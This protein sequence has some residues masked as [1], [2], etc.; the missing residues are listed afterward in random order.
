MT[1]CSPPRRRLSQGPGRSER[2]GAGNVSQLKAIICTRYGSPDVLRLEDVQKPTPKDDEL[3]IKVHAASV[4]AAD[5]ELL[6]GKPFFVRLGGLR[7]P[8]AKI[9]GSDIAGT[10]VA[11]GRNVTRFRPG[12]E[13]FGDLSDCGFGAFAEYVCAREDAVAL[14]PADLS[15][16]DAAAVPQAGVL[17]LQGLRDQRSIR[18]GDSVLINGAGGGAGTFAVQIAK[19][20]GAEVTGVDSADKLDLVRSIGADHVIDYKREDFTRNGQHYDLILDTV[21][22][23]SMSAYRRALSA[24]GAF[25]MIGGATRTIL[26]TFTIGTRMSRQGDQKLGLLMGKRSTADL[27]SLAEMV[28]SGLVDPVIGGRYALGDVPEAL[29]Q[30]EAGRAFGKLV[31][32][33]EQ[34]GNSSGDM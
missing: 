20:Y 7:A 18:T 16:E 34:G 28:Q 22:N 5:M 10:V 12:D 23:R 8:M 14:R 24:D 33:I 32:M 9:L 4:N 19:S 6:S 13:V 3:L 30:L 1:T 25:V 21:A 31:I 15:V 29:R 26:E 27:L 2:Y 17:A 11:V